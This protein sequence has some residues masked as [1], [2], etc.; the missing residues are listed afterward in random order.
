MLK[1]EEKITDI[2]NNLHSYLAY[3]LHY[4][5]TD[6]YQSVIFLKKKKLLKKA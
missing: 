1:C 5:Q 2:N 6:Y 3:A 4:I